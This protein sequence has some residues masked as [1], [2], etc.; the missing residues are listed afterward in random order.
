MVSD[1]EAVAITEGR[2]RNIEEATV[3]FS[4]PN[5]FPDIFTVSDMYL[6]KGNNF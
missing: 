2:L 6:G 5:Q 1:K 4:F 3:I